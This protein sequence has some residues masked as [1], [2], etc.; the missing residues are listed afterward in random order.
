MDV[1]IIYRNKALL[2]A[3][4]ETGFCRYNPKHSKVF[5]SALV[6]IEHTH[7][8]THTHTYTHIY[9]FVYLFI[10]YS[11]ITSGFTSILDLI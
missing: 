1:H 3:D 2:I 8:R 4:V 6:E 11:F 10:Y 5:V 7:A 9:L